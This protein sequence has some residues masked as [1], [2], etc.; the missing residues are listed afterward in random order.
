[1]RNVI[2]HALISSADFFFK[3]NFSRT[4]SV[5]QIRPGYHQTTLVGKELNSLEK[6]DPLEKE[7]LRNGKPQIRSYTVELPKKGERI[8]LNWTKL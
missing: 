7:T 6:S 5:K 4:Q 2:L 1:M 3:I 8:E